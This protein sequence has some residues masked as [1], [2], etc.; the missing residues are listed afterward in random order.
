MN[1]RYKFVI[2]S[3]VQ[4]AGLLISLS[5]HACSIKELDQ[6]GFLAGDVFS[7]GDLKLKIVSEDGPWDPKYPPGTTHLTESYVVTIDLKAAP[8]YLKRGVQLK[9]G[10]LYTDTV[11]GQEVTIVFRSKGNFKVTAF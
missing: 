6:N 4:I 7:A 3:A 2:T 11:C 10:Q 5:S 1:L 9:V 8:N